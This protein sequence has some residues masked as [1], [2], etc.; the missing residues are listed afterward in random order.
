MAQVKLT[1]K[2]KSVAIN[3]EDFL[4]K[5]GLSLHVDSGEGVVP[6]S[7]S[8]ADVLKLVEASIL[9]LAGCAVQSPRGTFQVPGKLGKVKT[10]YYPKTRR[11]VLGGKEVDIPEKVRFSYSQNKRMGELLLSVFNSLSEEQKK[12]ISSK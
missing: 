3:I 1:N 7:D 5:Q 8:L 4:K 10:V 2:Q 6:L 12:E 11:K 9:A